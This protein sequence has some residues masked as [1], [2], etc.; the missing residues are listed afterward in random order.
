MDL[1]KNKFLWYPLLVLATIFAIDKIFA[2]PVVLENTVLWKKIEPMFYES[3]YHLFD[4]LRE[5]YPKLAPADRK[6]GLIFGSS[7]GGEFNAEDFARE[8]PGVRAYNFSAP[9]APPSY[10]YYWL[11]RVLAADMR[12]AFVIIECDPLLFGPSA[13]G[14]SLAYSY[15]ADFVFRHV[16]VFPG[17]GDGFEAE[18]P[19]F[20]VDEAETFFLKRLFALYRYPLEWKT[21]EENNETHSA[22]VPG[23]GL[24]SIKGKEFKKNLTEIVRASNRRNLGGIPNPLKFSLSPEEI[25]KDADRM[26]ELHLGRGFPSRSQIVFFKKAIRRLA[27]EKIPVVVYWPL[28]SPALR[29]KYREHDLFEKFQK[30][31]LDFLDRTRREHPRARI[32]FLDP[33]DDEELDCR[34]FI[35][36]SHLSGA[37]FPQITERILDRLPRKL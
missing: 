27:A 5:E 18:G 9:L 23:K 19:G 31:L 16:D 20:S 11:D 26:E 34:V 21:I 36:A 30:P 13:A 33:Y 15:D 37:C 1:F 25:Q 2:L 32:A 22:I 8:R 28:S 29:E 3:R 12:P 10:F 4:Q 17:P 14:Y 24:V 35:D 6:L 7:R